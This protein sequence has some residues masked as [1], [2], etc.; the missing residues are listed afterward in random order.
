MCMEPLRYFMVVDADN[1]D[2]LVHLVPNGPESAIET[3]AAGHFTSGGFR[4]T[5]GCLQ[6][7][8]ASKQRITAV[9]TGTGIIVYAKAYKP[10]GIFEWTFRKRR[11][12][13]ERPDA[14]NIRY[15]KERVYIPQ[16]HSNEGKR[17]IGEEPG[18]RPGNDKMYG[19]A[20]AVYGR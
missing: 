10:P 5:W 18:V 4:R 20:G 2:D 9:H 16:F 11:S 1:A 8:C 7:A 12:Y 15:V 13:A 14:N 3:P 19:A 17:K 6:L